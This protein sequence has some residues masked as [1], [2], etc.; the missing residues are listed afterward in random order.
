MKIVQINAVYKYSSTG[1][2]T[3]EMHVFLRNK[4]YESF[5]FCTNYEQPEI[6]VFKV[7]N[8][9]DYKMHGLLSRLLGLQGYF[10]YF[11]TRKLVKQLKQI[12][13]DI[14][15]LRN[16]HSNF[17]NISMLLKYIG[18]NNIKLIWVQ[19]DCW[20]YT[21]HCTHY[22]MNGCY[23]W[24]TEC[25]DCR[26]IRARDESW[27]IDT[28]RFVYRD[29]KKMLDMIDDFTVVGVSQWITE[30]AKQSSLFSHAKRFIRIYNW[31]NH[32][33]FYPRNN[34]DIRKQLRLKEDDFV[35]IG[36]AQLW[37]NKK[38]LDILIEVAKRHPDWKFVL[39]GRVLVELPDNMNAVG[40]ISDTSLLADYYSMA[41]VLV[42]FSQQESFGKVAA[43]ALS[44]GTPVIANN[45]TANPEVVGDCGVVIRNNDI[46]EF[47]KAV[48]K[49][50]DIEKDVMKEMCYKR[51][52]ELFSMNKNIEN[53]LELFETLHLS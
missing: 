32:D 21:G 53:Y 44:C 37:S 26:F 24:K 2:T 15:I 13:P 31:I 8:K 20:A 29:R 38:G 35:L 1:R 16:L 40:T 27:F 52:M 5:V 11:S 25:H 45:N 41:D 49:I 36:I 18:V 48:N 47:E 12:L 43:E 14:V 34:L 28:S 33:V 39:I 23:K 51:S 46:I 10:S 6:G 22:T 9:L 17:V 30:E 19:H 50:M 3:E 42:N 7:G 4:G